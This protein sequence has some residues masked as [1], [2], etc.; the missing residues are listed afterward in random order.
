[1]DNVQQIYSKPSM[2]QPAKGRLSWFSQEPFFQA[3]EVGRCSG[4]CDFTNNL[5]LGNTK[6]EI[7]QAFLRKPW[8]GYEN[9]LNFDNRQ[10]K[11]MYTY[12]SFGAK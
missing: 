3:S 6:M 9:M 5:R 10:C 2:C 1:M 4:S 7:R 11:T 8:A 12:A